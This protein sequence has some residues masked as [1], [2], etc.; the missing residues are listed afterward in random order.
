LG[1]DDV[2]AQNITVSA[3]N[4]SNR[5]AELASIAKSIADAMAEELEQYYNGDRKN[6]ASDDETDDDFDE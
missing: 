6:W 5:Y 4:I 3:G 2:A 1:A